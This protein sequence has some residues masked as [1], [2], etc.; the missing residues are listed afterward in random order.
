MAKRRASSRRPAPRALGVPTRANGI[1]PETFRDVV[2]LL[3]ATT[4]RLQRL[5]RLVA[6]YL[7][8]NSTEY[9]IVAALSR[10]RPKGGVR[11]REIADYLHMAPENV[12]TAV[13]KLVAAKWIVKEVDPSD[14]R[15]VTL[16]LQAPM[17]GRMDRLTD[18]LQEVNAQWFQELNATDLQQL[19]SYLERVVQGF[20]AGL[21]KA[22]E[23]F[24]PRSGA[25]G[26]FHGTA[27]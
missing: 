10:L 7:D 27:R 16:R 18:A 2:M 4:G 19:T 6:S 13:G 8:L 23:L 12:T 14:A 25:L 20:D 22:E 5:R 3:Y 15:A 26:N 11:V 17:Q 21:H 24:R 9:L 1:R